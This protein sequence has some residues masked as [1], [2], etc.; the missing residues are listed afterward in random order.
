MLIA[1]DPGKVCGYIV[2][3][4]DGGVYR[5]DEA[6]PYETVAVIESLLWGQEHVDVIVERFIITPQTHKMTR[7]YDAIETIGALRYVCMKTP[8]NSFHLQPRDAKTRVKNATLKVLGWYMATNDQH[9][10]DA[11]KHAFTAFVN[12]RPTSE[13][14]RRGLD[15]LLPPTE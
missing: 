8:N 11:A 12:L 5:Q 1:V 4:D 13:V 6:S 10:N 14:T 15:S 2:V 3:N 9:A 7:Q